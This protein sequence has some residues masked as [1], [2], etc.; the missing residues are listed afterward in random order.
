MKSLKLTILILIIFLKTGNVL[1]EKNLFNVNNIEI[2]N[3]SRVNNEALANKAIKK[4][5]YELID[6]ILLTEDAE[7]LKKLSFS[8]IKDLVSYY[9]IKAEN[10]KVEKPKTFFNVFFD[11]VKIHNLFFKKDISYSD[12]VND[13][14][15]LLPILKKENKLYI[16]TQN[17]FYE[18]WKEVSE[19]K[20]VEFILPLE[21]IETIQKINSNQNNLLDVDIRNIFQEYTKKN[22]ALVFIEDT[23]SNEEKV[24]LK[25]VIMG[26]SINKV[27]IV[28]RPNL[29]QNQFYEKIILET[30]KEI[31]NLVKLQNLIDI[32]T[33][34]FIN[35]TFNITK[36][37]SL[38]ELNY[39][40]NK[41]DL[42]ENIYILELNKEYISLKIK[43]LGKIKKIIDQLES[44][45]IILK[46]KDDQW[47]MKLI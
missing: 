45:Q 8:E 23:K 32:R 42:I 17:Y 2:I 9:Q 34:S 19:N 20:L 21:N 37:N 46:F 22:L 4:G 39:R 29:D 38:K 14:L 13:E 26:K 36:K 15:Y 18:K 11:K 5:F 31:I 33:P 3:G 25:T 44:Q 43:Y 30:K 28:K 7:R 12:I 1:S 40:L 16:Y 6:R 10:N 35:A 41:I 27:I 24:F 47:I